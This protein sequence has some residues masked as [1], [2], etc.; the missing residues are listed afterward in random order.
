[1]PQSKPPKPISPNDKFR[2][3]LS[4]CRVPSP[5]T[6]HAEI[7]RVQRAAI[8]VN[9]SGVWLKSK[10]IGQIIRLRVGIPHRSGQSPRVRT[11]FVNFKM[12]PN[13]GSRARCTPPSHRVKLR[14]AARVAPF[15][16]VANRRRHMIVPSAQS[17]HTTMIAVSA[18]Y[19]L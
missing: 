13:R 5:A 19:A 18:Q 14:S 16:R 3:R 4:R 7:V 10:P 17:S 2:N 8:G 15:H 11:P 1:M 6:C 12:L 9:G